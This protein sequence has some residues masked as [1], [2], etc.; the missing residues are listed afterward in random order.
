[1]QLK[2]VY[3]VLQTKTLIASKTFWVNLFTTLIALVTAVSNQDWV[4]E[5]PQLTPVLVALVSVLNIAL[6][7]VTT[8]PI[9]AV[10]MLL[11]A[12]GLL[13]CAGSADAYEQTY[14][15][16]TYDQLG[17]YAGSATKEEWEASNRA[18]ERAEAIRDAQ[19][20]A[21]ANERKAAASQSWK[22]K[23][24]LPSPSRDEADSQEWREAEVAK[25]KAAY[26]REQARKA[27]KAGKSKHGKSAAISSHAPL[28]LAF[29]MLGD[30]TRAVHV[31]AA[32]LFPRLRV[33]QLIWNTNGNGSACAN[34]QC[35]I[36]AVKPMPLPAKP[37]PSATKPV[38]PLAPKPGPVLVK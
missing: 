18:I 30:F 3:S 12:V 37:L 15:G 36:K 6:R 22:P 26:D 33:L 27:K 35:E 24:P 29:H 11:I 19:Q 21:E 9:N 28:A 14:G 10:V 23:Q 4:A 38:K 13:G 20:R 25:W 7:Y 31:E 17:S 32:I 8:K 1:M 2:G 34:G 5:H 16:Y